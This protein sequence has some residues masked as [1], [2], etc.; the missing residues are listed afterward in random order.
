MVTVSEEFFDV[1]GIPLERGRA[2]TGGDDAGAESVVILSRRL[3]DALWPDRDALGQY[4]AWPAIEGPERPPLRVVGIAADTR[5]VIPGGE[6][7]LF[8][9]VPFAQSAPLGLTLVVRARGKAPVDEATWRSIGTRARPG[10]AVTHV[11]TLFERLS[12]EFRPERMA[13]AWVGVF[14]LIALLLATLGLYGVLAQAVLQRTRELAVRSALG[15]AP[16][17]L[18]KMVTTEGARLAVAGCVLGA[19]GAITAFKVIHGMFTTVSVTDI[20]AATVALAF[21]AAAMLVA[22]WIP[23]RR[24]ARLDPAGLLRS[25]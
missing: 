5:P 18:I 10:V 25:D 7:P 1:M 20:G 8:M 19:V 15:A 23:A 14:G 2:F 22:T 4:V 24:A 6:P 12:S 3:S 17:D 16:I 21:L 9:Y 13:S 11:G